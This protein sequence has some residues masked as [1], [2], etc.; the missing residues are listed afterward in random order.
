LANVGVGA[1]AFG[2]LGGV[3]GGISNA[4][5]GDGT[6]ARGVGACCVI[7][8]FC[9]V[10]NSCVVRNPLCYTSL[11]RSHAHRFTSS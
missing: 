7:R 1:L 8:G 9:F 11:T 10:C 2:F 3:L 5:T 4:I 6:F